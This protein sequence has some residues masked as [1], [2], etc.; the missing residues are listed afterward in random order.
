MHVDDYVGGVGYEIVTRSL[1]VTMH[2]VD[3]ACGVWVKPWYG[4]RGSSSTT[5]EP[6]G[7]SLS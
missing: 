3:C 1:D 2:E 4:W 5:Q 6:I 7:L